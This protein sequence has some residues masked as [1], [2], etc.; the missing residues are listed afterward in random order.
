M[1]PI[2]TVISGMILHPIARA[3]EVL[4]LYRDFVAS[5][6]PDELTI[7][8]AA[9][10]SPNG[11]PVIGY[12]PRWCGDD[13]TKG[14][15]GPAVHR[16]DASIPSAMRRWSAGSV[17]VNSLDQDDATRIPEAYGQNYQKLSAV[18]A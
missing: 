14:V 3:R 13:L 16:L 1:Y 17:Y 18:K 5:G 7:Y 9:L 10:S 8:A 15:R 6:L 12:I 4:K 2:T 11:H